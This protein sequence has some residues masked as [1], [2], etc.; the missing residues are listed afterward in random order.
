MTDAA[1]FRLLSTR[2]AFAAADGWPWSDRLH[3]LY[4]APG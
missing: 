2:F 4:P 3:N 1:G